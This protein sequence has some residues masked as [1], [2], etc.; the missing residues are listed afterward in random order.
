MEENG[1]QRD[2]MRMDEKVDEL[3]KDV[4]DRKRTDGS[5]DSGEDG[6]GNTCAMNHSGGDKS[7]S[8]ASRSEEKDGH[9][10]TDDV[11]AA[12]TGSGDAG[13]PSGAVSGEADRPAGTASTMSAP[14][15]GENG[16]G[17]DGAGEEDDGG[18]GYEIDVPGE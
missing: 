9:Q 7:D 4:G 5:E 12:G 8:I 15:Q 14:Q 3:A 17:D 10:Q 11:V 1:D 13:R 18:S 16:E 6:K 2:G